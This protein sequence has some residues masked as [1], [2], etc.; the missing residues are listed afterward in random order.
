[1]VIFCQITAVKAAPLFLITDSYMPYS[2][3]VDGEAKG[4]N[5][6]AVKEVMQR[7]NVSYPI[8]FLPWKRGMKILRERSR[9]ALFPVVYTEQRAKSL[10]FA[11]SLA[12]DT[13][14]FY[15]LK[16]RVFERKSLNDFRELNVAYLSGSVG[17]KYL[18]EQNFPNITALSTQEQVYG[19]LHK[20]RVDL[21]PQGEDN[22][23][24]VRNSQY[25]SELL[26]NTGVK[27]LET[28]YCVAFS[29]DVPD[30]EVERWEGALAD[31][32]LDGSLAKI[33]LRYEAKLL[34]SK[35]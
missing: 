22:V 1:M 5:V 16:S 32:A 28:K 24:A 9:K 26:Q 3:K 2:Y 14:F 35:Q 30:S 19:M 29:K 4:V 6:D 7:I 15:A 10:K 18:K 25:K 34:E 20:G 23:S 8:N 31:M 13:L 11:C 21:I 27:L 12:T 33:R 17:E